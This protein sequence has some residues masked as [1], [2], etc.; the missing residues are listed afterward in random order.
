VVSAVNPLA[1]FYDIRGGKEEARR[2]WDNNR[3]MMTMICSRPTIG[4]KSI[5]V[6]GFQISKNPLV[7]L[8]FQAHYYDLSDNSV[9]V[10]HNKK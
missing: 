5:A 1:A 6:K 7:F 8:S 3:L 4:E 10:T 2:R 9:P